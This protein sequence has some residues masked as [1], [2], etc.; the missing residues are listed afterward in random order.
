MYAVMYMCIPWGGRELKN[1][2]TQE[3]QPHKERRKCLFSQFA[4]DSEISIQG[5]NVDQKI[6]HFLKNSRW[7][8]EFSISDGVTS[9][10]FNSVL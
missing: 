10:I 9:T 8:E 1:S 3:D 6:K 2:L 4:I 5:T 7:G